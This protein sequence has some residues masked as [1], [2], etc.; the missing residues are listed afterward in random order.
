MIYFERIIDIT[1]GEETIRPYTAEEIA[2]VEALQAQLAAE[3]AKIDAE[4]SAKEAAR[5]AVL[6]KL[7]LSADEVAALLG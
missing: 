7:G 2:E 3:Q 6:D 4:V 5:Q 1:T